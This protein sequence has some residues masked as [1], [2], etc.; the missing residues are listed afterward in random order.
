MVSGR[1]AIQ[2]H[3]L[4]YLLGAHETLR[5]RGTPAENHCHTQ[6]VHEQV[7]VVWW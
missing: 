5:V 7:A 6:F 1:Y 4:V 2:I 3:I